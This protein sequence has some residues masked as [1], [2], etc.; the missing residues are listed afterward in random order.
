M[1]LI[2][3]L[4]VIAIIGVL[5]ALLLPAIQSGRESARRTQCINNLRQMVITAHMYADTH[6]G[7]YPI[8][9]HNK[10]EGDT[11]YAYCWDIS[12]I[13]KEGQ[14]TVTAPGILWGDD[15]TPRD[16]NQCPSLVSKGNFE[17]DPY[18]GYNYNTSYIG[19]G[20]YESIPQPAKMKQ[21]ENPTRT[22][23]F[24][25]GEYKPG[26]NK[27]MRAPFA[28]PGDDSFSGRWAGTQGFRH[29]ST[30]NVAFCDGHATSLA[31]RYTET[32]EYNGAANIGAG[33]GFLSPDN[34]MYG[35]PQ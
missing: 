34:S 6:A 35:A 17:V 20:D 9:Y 8:A 11:L 23:I 16:I 18:T 31:D 15:T 14:P 4:V 29:L 25:D 30:T 21:I 27:F 28:S 1:S 7:S 22:A 12:T 5:I 2:E 33:T 19:H 3:L 10:K 24:G 26:A 13:V 32:D